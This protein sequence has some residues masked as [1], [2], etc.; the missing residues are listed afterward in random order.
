VTS[1]TRT[2]IEFADVVAVEFECTKCSTRITKPFRNDL[3]I[4]PHCP[5]CHNMFFIENSTPQQHLYLT[6]VT[7]RTMGNEKE[8]PCRLRLEIKPSTK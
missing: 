7:I 5:N 8:S 4:P 3:A 1:E 2:M 6:L